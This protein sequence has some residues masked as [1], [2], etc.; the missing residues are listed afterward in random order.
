MRLRHCDCGRGWLCG[1][2]HLLPHSF[3]R[4]HTQ[5]KDFVRQTEYGPWSALWLATAF[6]RQVGVAFPETKVPEHAYNRV[7]V[8]ASAVAGDGQG[9]RQ[10]R[11]QPKTQRLQTPRLSSF[12][13]SQGARTIN[14]GVIDTL[15]FL[16]EN[17]MSGSSTE[18]ETTH[19]KRVQC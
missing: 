19:W 14:R 11:M 6:C 2:P 8:R 3:A 10:S 1:S 15:P 18:P 7:S 12:G 5:T 9:A 13:R 16:L 4:R 17:P